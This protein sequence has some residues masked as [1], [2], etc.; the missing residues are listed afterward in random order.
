[1]WRN[2]R[3]SL[4][5][6][7]APLS[8]LFYSLLLLFTPVVLAQ[9]EELLTNKTDLPLWEQSG[10]TPAKLDLALEGWKKRLD[11]LPKEATEKSVEGQQR[12]A[13]KERIG[14]LSEWKE[15]LERNL[16]LQ[17]ELASL[18]ANREEVEKAL[19]QQ[20][21][22]QPSTA[23]S[24]P[25]PQG[26]ES[27]RA[28]MEKSQKELATIQEKLK[29]R[30]ELITALPDRLAAFKE[31]LKTYRK[32]AEQYVEMAKK[33]SGSDQQILLFHGDSARLGIRLVEEGIDLLA[34][35]QRFQNE[36]LPLREKKR[37]L[38]ASRNRWNEQAFILYQSS[39]NQRQDSVVKQKAAELFEKTQN[40]QLAVSPDERFLRKWEAEIARLQKNLADL[41]KLKTD[42]LSLSAEQ[43]KLLK[44]EQNELKN[45]QEMLKKNGISDNTANILKSVFQRLELRRKS[46][47]SLIPSSI[48]TKLQAVSSRLHEIDTE[49]F[50]L[51]ERWRLEQ[52][53]AGQQIEERA[54]KR[55]EKE[56]DHLFKS[57]RELLGQ[58]KQ[59]LLEVEGEER[60]LSLYPSEREEALLLLETFVRSKVFW[61][62]DADP[63]NMKMISLMLR[64][65]FSPYKPHSL[66]NWW[67][68]ALSKETIAHF[69]QALREPS[70]LLLFLVLAIGFP[71]GYLPL[72][73]RWHVADQEAL[74]NKE[75][76]STS[77]LSLT[78]IIRIGLIPFFLYLLY[79]TIA[80]AALPASIGLVTQRV[81]LHVALFF[82]AWGI[83]RHMVHPT[84]VLA[85]KF[86]VPEPVCFSL[87]VSIRLILL[88]Y[89]AFLLP[90]IIFKDAPFNF[91]AI[92]RLGY[93]L[94]ELVTAIAIFSLIRH[95]SPLVRHTFSTPAGPK[96]GGGGASS[97]QPGFL[98]H[99]WPLISKL[100]TLFMISVVGLDIMG[101]RFG[102]SR[103]ASNGL[104][105]LFTLF[106]LV[107]LFH[108]SLA[109]L[110]TMIRSR[111][112]IPTAN[113]PGSK[114]TESRS[115]FIGQIR[116][117]LRL[118]FLVA[119]AYLFAH[120]WGLNKSVFHVLSEYVLY[121]SAGSEGTLEFITLA[122]LTRFLIGLIFLIWVT[123]HLPRLF[124]LILF[125]RVPF[126]AGLRYAIVTMSR[127]LIILVGLFI[128]FSFLK[129]D[130]AKVGWL[131]AAISVGL[132]FGLQ[133]IVAN[134]VSGIILLLERPIRVGD[135]IT[136]GASFGRV[137]RINIRSTTILTPDIQ[138]LLIPNRDLITKEVTNWTLASSNIR[139]IVLIG[140][141]YGSDVEKVFELL[142]SIAKAQP[143]VL[144]EPKPEV[145]FM[146]HGA[147]SLDFELR[148]FL[149][150]PTLR[151]PM[152]SKLNTLIN[153]GLKA[154]NIEIPFPQQDI[155]IRSGLIPSGK[156]A[157][158]EE[159]QPPVEDQ[160]Q[161]VPG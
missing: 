148:V 24:D 158:P 10:M 141:A 80:V 11:E 81:L 100:I 92:P 137:T 120:F 155:H 86:K 63:I 44:S 5:C 93:T 133:E 129:L 122:D 54:L 154:N 56:A 59:L 112:R 43:E 90:W 104:L 103:L 65:A 125:S 87:F 156:R 35:E 42:L 84:G 60:R 113:A 32:D 152:L 78:V 72:R 107:G 135:L 153:A 132:G 126:D 131:V 48:I 17:E 20:E 18:S 39:L 97:V 31:R 34:N 101:Y 110:E 91:T 146:A 49:L 53:L 140:V 2:R 77:D 27:Y 144:V 38:F 79:Q 7:M 145:L 111:R 89:L 23:P 40:A 62:Q 50:D 85:S 71:M 123:R 136:V 16:A 33:K 138:E 69:Y 26:L 9:S 116:G 70:F 127:Y 64:E 74:C 36:I 51:R 28:V 47:S 6:L 128:T 160:K 15:I 161:P 3:F 4:L 61:V 119:G 108:A 109:L 143:E 14:R 105:T 99:N 117:T 21:K 19:D 25:T 68:E 13:W 121:S 151:M 149:S 102:A 94:F 73:H 45:L 124:E 130:L 159:K 98:A 134:F 8:V 57:Y 52:D 41:N 82:L 1:M 76:R 12:L 88:V 30:N 118:L 37:D 139:L 67:R 95:T 142:Y 58:E 46:L 115:A 83:N 96:G 29:E 150:N 75:K 147:S 55:L 106:A 66:Y 22:K 157:E 114:A